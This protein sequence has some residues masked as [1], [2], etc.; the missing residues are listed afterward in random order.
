MMTVLRHVGQNGRE[1]GR[2]LDNSSRRQRNQGLIPCANG[3]SLTLKGTSSLSVSPESY[4]VPATS[5]FQFNTFNQQW[6]RH[7]FSTFKPSLKDFRPRM[8][9]PICLRIHN[10]YSQNSPRIDCKRSYWRPQMPL[11]WCMTWGNLKFCCWGIQDSSIISR[12][13]RLVARKPELIWNRKFRISNW[14]NITVCEDNCRFAVL[15]MKN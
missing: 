11:A 9:R 6:H 12:Y 13:V 3:T 4:D 2:W 7:Y 15:I 14:F 8:K 10:H 5:A 1:K